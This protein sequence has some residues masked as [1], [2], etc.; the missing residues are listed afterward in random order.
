[1]LVAI[2]NCQGRVSPVF[3]VAARL[4]TVRLKGGEEL[5]RREVTLFETRPAEIARSL[6]ELGTKV[7]ICGAI[8]EGLEGALVCAGI[9]VV[10]RI[11]GE[12]EAVLHAYETG[13]LAAPEFQMPGCCG[14]RADASPGPAA[15][16]CRRSRVVIGRSS[17]VPGPR[18]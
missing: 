8:S 14:K 9:R 4:M 7:L 18:G 15:K 2:P 12:V 3:D 5:G 10:P 16:C 13:R 17:K 6:V 11:C 1:M